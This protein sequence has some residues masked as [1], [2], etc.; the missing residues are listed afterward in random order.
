MEPKNRKE[1]IGSLLAVGAATSSLALSLVSGGAAVAAAPAV[2][3]C[4]ATVDDI[5][6]DSS[7]KVYNDAK[8]A[9]YLKSPAAVKL[10]KDVAAKTK[11]YKAAKTKSAKAKAK[12]ALDLAKKKQ[13][14]AIAAFKKSNFYYSYSGSATPA[15]VTRSN[16]DGLWSWGVYTT[17]VM[18]NKRSLTAVCTYVDETDAGSDLGVAATEQDKL[19]SHHLYQGPDAGM[20]QQ[21]PGQLPV[22][23]YATLAQ[24]AKDA[25]AIIGNVDQCIAQD[26]GVTTAPCIKG[27]LADLEILGGMTGATYTVTGYRGSLQAALDRAVAAAQIVA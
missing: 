1:L 8:L 10:A 24:P 7:L 22:L 20:D 6:F 17:R 19:D 12:Q 11:A 18:V 25:S 16:A 5:A 26:W 14:T 13:A 3:G 23:W 2:P 4:D 9:G 15:P 21:I 27:G